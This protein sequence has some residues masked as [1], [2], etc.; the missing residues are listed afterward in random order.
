M[1]MNMLVVG[2][3]AAVAAGGV[4][5]VFI[6]PLL[7]GDARA[8]RRQKALMTSKQEGRE[9]AAHSSR[10]EQIAQTLKELEARKGGK[11][12]TIEQ[13]ITQAGLSWSK[14]QFF[15]ISAAIGLSCTAMTFLLIGNL[16]ATAGALVAGVLGVPRWLLGFLKKRRINKFL[17]ELPNAM[18][19]I[20]RG[21][22][23]GLPLA[24]CLRIIGVEAK[25][26]LRSEFRSVIDTQALG[27]PLGDAVAKM[28]ER[29]PVAETN[30]FG[31]VISVQQK[32][33]GN[34]AETLGNL[35]KVLRE[36]KKMQGKIKAM[37]MEAKASAGIIGALPFV[38]ATLTYVSSPSYVRLLFVTSAGNVALVCSALWM[39]CGIFVMKKMINFDH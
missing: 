23:S 26:P 21:L 7:S 5:Y 3:L 18:D 36:R 22:R 4:A 34:L 2:T 31:I 6:Y 32:S 29:V 16:F 1:K 28:Y 13:R 15:L 25:E 14:S 10:R 39:L 19:V 27:I 37:S 11:T 12:V 8:E 20:V 38:V 33:G 35:S 9:R 17:E 30:F 24:D